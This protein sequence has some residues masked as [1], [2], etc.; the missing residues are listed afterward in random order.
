MNSLSPSTREI[1]IR[2]KVV[3]S[4]TVVEQEIKI[5]WH[6]RPTIC[7]SRWWVSESESTRIRREHLLVLCSGQQQ[8]EMQSDSETEWENE[9]IRGSPKADQRAQ[10]NQEWDEQTNQPRVWANA[11]NW[12]LNQLFRLQGQVLSTDSRR[13]DGISIHHDLSE[14]LRVGM[15]TILRRTS[16]GMQWTIWPVSTVLFSCE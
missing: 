9:G 11:E 8:V 15:G 12:V 5:S 14:C 6:P 13:S 1:E 7:L 3:K 16:T 10:W 2:R 4:R